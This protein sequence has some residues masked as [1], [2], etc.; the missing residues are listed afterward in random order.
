MTGENMSENEENSGFQ[1]FTSQ[2]LRLH[3]KGSFENLLCQH[4][5]MAVA[6]DPLTKI[7]LI[8][9]AGWMVDSNKNN[10]EMTQVEAIYSVALSFLNTKQVD[11]FLGIAWAFTL[12]RDNYNRFIKPWRRVTPIGF[13]SYILAV[14][15]ER[16]KILKEAKNEHERFYLLT[17][18]FNL[19]V[20]SFQ[21]L[22]SEFLRWAL[23]LVMEIFEKL[24]RLVQP[25][26][27]K[28]MPQI[29]KGEITQK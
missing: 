6:A 10:L 3:R 17:S 29:M 12:T 13:S 16:R 26:L 7:R 25:D 1:E 19:H 20:S 18:K 28:E 4:L 11:G 27:Y 14:T 21:V 23:P 22:K 2:A 9:E 8:C 24:S 15:Q 5:V